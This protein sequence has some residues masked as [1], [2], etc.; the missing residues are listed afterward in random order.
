[1]I[2]VMFAALGVDASIFLWVWV[3]ALMRSRSAR[4][5]GDI[6]PTL[7]H[8][9]IGFITNVFDTLGVGS[10]ATTSSL[11]KLWQVV[12]DE[13]M[14]GTLNVG[15]TLP[16]VLQA[17][18][19]MTFVHVDMT[20]LMPM[21][22]ATIVGAWLGAEVV[23]GWPRR[24]IQIGMGI[25]LLL[26]AT[27]MVMT[28]LSLFPPGGDSLGLW[29]PKLIVAVFGNFMLAMLMM[30]GIGFY[31]PCMVMVCLLGMTPAAAFPIMMSSCAFMMPVGSIPFI[32]RESYNVKAA[33]GLA[34]GG[35]PGVLAVAILVKSLPLTAVRWLVIAVVIYAATMMLRS[36][37]VEARSSKV[38]AITQ[39]PAGIEIARSNDSLT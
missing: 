18:L 28:Q 11:F 24:K 29:G 32:R 33:L 27:A 8:Y 3:M 4:S 38:K 6:R 30:L 2:A 35:L 5:R 13:Q 10:F 39:D 21:V 19:Y 26:A 17:F 15:H 23:A 36:A 20:T 1:M 34:L 37:V 31:A 14:P 9:G 12:R 25:A 22:G 16:S 7:R